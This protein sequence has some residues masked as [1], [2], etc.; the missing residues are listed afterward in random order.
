MLIHIS[1]RLAGKTDIMSLESLL[2]ELGIALAFRD[3]MHQQE[4]ALEFIEITLTDASSSSQD[5]RD[6]I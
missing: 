5:C 6:R 2:E 3:T 1:C 4:D